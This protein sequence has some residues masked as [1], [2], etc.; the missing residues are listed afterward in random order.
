MEALARQ[1]LTLAAP[2]RPAGKPGYVPALPTL[3]PSM[4][5]SSP[6]GE[7]AFPFDSPQ[8]R[9]FYFARNAVWL[10]TKVL[11]LEG[12]EVLVPA[13]HHGVEVEALVDAGA[14]VRFF[15]VD[16]RMRPDLGDLERKI[17]PDTRGVYLIHY[18]GFPGPAAEVRAIADRRGLAFI[19]DCALSLLS[20]DGQLPLGRTGDASVFCLY[21]TL[22]VPHGGALVLAGGRPAG[23]PEPLPPPAVA[24]A[25]HLMTS[26][27]MNLELRLGAAGRWMRGGVRALGRGA[28]A[29]AGV[30]NVAT[31]TQHFERDHSGLGIS[32]LALRL[33]LG[34]DAAEIV[35]TRRRNYFLLL[36]RLREVSTPVFNTLPAGVCPLFFPLRVQ[37]KA[38]VAKRLAA[39]GI[40]TVDFWRTGHAACELDAFPEVRE[41]RRTI[42]EIPI[43]QD[44]TPRAAAAVAESVHQVLREVGP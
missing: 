27:L 9:Y 16:S 30:G 14:K 40:E 22:P 41:L 20:C 2:P 1:P 43:H 21:K 42:L 25:R 32:P 35:A 39:R 36:S 15:R 13:Y 31:G 37:D 29:A 5:W 7:Q 26:L 3:W 38:A 4:L 34:Q 28:S 33:A 8:V 12:H 24:T 10:A 6:R 23:L 18:L 44:L 19:E 11:G 17:G